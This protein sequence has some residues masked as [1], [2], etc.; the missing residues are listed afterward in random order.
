MR[1]ILCRAFFKTHGKEKKI[2]LPP[3]LTSVSKGAT[4]VREKKFAVLKGLSCVQKNARQTIF[5][6]VYSLCRAPYMKR[7]AK[8]LFAV[9]PIENTRQTFSHMAKLG[10]P[11]SD[12]A[13]Y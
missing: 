9:R 10:F 11:S 6:G 3:V 12:N 8:K 1:K 2:W 13:K 5:S 7:M 4:D